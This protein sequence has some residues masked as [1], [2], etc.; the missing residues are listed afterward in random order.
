MVVIHA[1]I[2]YN[3]LYAAR[4]KE[5]EEEEREKRKRKASIH[6][7][8]T[9]QNKTILNYPP[10]TLGLRQKQKW[11]TS[12]WPS[13]FSTPGTLG[14][15]EETLCLQCLPSRLYLE[16]SMSSSFHVF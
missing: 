9:L 13:V 15:T 5:E 10:Q 7:I 14:R 12:R 6:T 11:L 1:V 2:S 3:I 8:R 16:E 4:M